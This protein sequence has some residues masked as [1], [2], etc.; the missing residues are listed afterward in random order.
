MVRREHGILNTCQQS[1]V[2]SD[3]L[4]FIHMYFEVKLLFHNDDFS[5]TKV[6]AFIFHVLITV[7]PYIFLLYLQNIKDKS[8]IKN[9]IEEINK[10]NC[11]Y[12]PTSLLW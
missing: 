1:I 4:F 9:L 12:K 7:V 3:E 10:Q 6:N 2:N 11:F 8:N 5:L